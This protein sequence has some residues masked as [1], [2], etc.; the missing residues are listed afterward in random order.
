MSM[1]LSGCKD[2]RIDNT[3]NWVGLYNSSHGSDTITN[4][5][6]TK[7]DDNSLQIEIKAISG[8]YLYTYTTLR[9]VAV[10]GMTQSTINESDNLITGNAGPYH[11]QGTVSLEGA[12]LTL[13]A[14]ATQGSNVVAVDFSGRKR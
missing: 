4:L 12:A 2:E 7:A 6:I 9:H 3:V 8:G 1:L 5:I 11:I 14:T 13:T 10:T